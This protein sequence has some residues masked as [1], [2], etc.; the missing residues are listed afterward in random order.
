MGISNPNGVHIKRSGTT[1]PVILI[2]QSEQFLTGC[3]FDQRLKDCR[4]LC[5]TT[6]VFL[7]TQDRSIWQTCLDRKQSKLDNY[8]LQSVAHVIDRM[9]RLLPLQLTS[10]LFFYFITAPRHLSKLFTIDKISR[11]C[12]SH[13][14]STRRRLSSPRQTLW[15]LPAGTIGLRR[16][17]GGVRRLTLQ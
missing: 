9:L 4:W 13:R 12:L 1:H 3:M 10:E 6:V 7:P 2:T 15:I 8:Y 5:F 16:P 14:H 11:F 17:A